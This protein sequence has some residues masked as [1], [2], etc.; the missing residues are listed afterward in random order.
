MPPLEPRLDVVALRP[1]FTA[2]DRVDHLLDPELDGD[3]PDVD[4]GL[5]GL[6]RV[7]AV[8][9]EG[10]RLGHEHLV[11]ACFQRLQERIHDPECAVE[12]STGDGDIEARP[13]ESDGLGLQPRPEEASFRLPD[14]RVRGPQ[15]L[16]DNHP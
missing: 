1:R 15:Y 4:S 6:P 13:L 5:A 10:P 2:S 14:E 7:A 9:R 8:T 16:R 12:V 11:P 3:V